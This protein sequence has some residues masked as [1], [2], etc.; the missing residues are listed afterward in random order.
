MRIATWNVNSLKARLPRVLDWVAAQQPDVLCLQETKLA[1][2]AFPY[3]ALESAGYQVTHHGN[4]R[5]NG[6]AIASRVGLADPVTGLAS[7]QWSGVAEPRLVAATCGGVR[8]VSVYV[9]NGRTLDDPHY[10]YKL[11]WLAEL[12]AL[13]GRERARYARYVVAG[14][15]NVAPTDEDV[16][17]AA[18]F[19]GAT[20]VSPP[21]RAALQTLFGEGQ[22]GLAGAGLADVARIRHTGPFYTYWDYRQG[23]FRR[24]LGMRIDLILASA[25]LAAELV[26]VW[27]DRVERRGGGEFKPS[28][29]APLV[30]DFA[31][32]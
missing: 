29:H 9:P 5:W 15:F 4:G 31:S 28:D 14:D 32:A 22:E 23:F 20:H 19:Q 11:S 24:D 16:F 2:A 30:A 3:A 25:D 26:E 1:D 21:E 6:V 17:D 10:T 7:P 12:A 18:A 27:V 8:V 13:V